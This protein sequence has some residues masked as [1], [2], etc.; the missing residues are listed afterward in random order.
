MHDKL[1][2]IRIVSSIGA[3]YGDLIATEIQEIVRR[4]AEP[5]EPGD[6]VKTQLARSWQN[7]GRPPFWR[8]KAGWY[9]DGASW[10]ARAVADFQARW[11]ALQAKR[12]AARLERA[13][14]QLAA[15]RSRDEFHALKLESAA[16]ALEATDDQFYRLDIER[17][18]NLACQLRDLAADG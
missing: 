8:L 13:K 18:R 1:S 15:T 7:L 12:D 17:L 4:A 10:S 5:L 3:E 6:T 2:E 11:V 9:G 16:A 14:A